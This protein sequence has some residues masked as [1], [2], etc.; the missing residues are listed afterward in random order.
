MLCHASKGVAIWFPQCRGLSTPI[1]VL[2]QHVSGSFFLIPKGIILQNLDVMFIVFV[3]FHFI[4][5]S[6]SCQC[7]FHIQF[8][9]PPF[10][11]QCCVHIAHH[12]HL[13]LQTEYFPFF[14]VSLFF[15]TKCQAFI[16]FLFKN[17]FPIGSSL[18]VFSVNEFLPCL[19][20]CVLFSCTLQRVKLP[21][22]LFSVVSGPIPPAKT[23]SLCQF[24]NYLYMNAKIIHINIWVVSTSNQ[25]LYTNCSR[26]RLKPF[27]ELIV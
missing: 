12:T 11:C 3:I 13:C 23:N 1:S 14:P 6:F 4:N 27:K 15:Q 26:V 7:C 25:Q 17:N 16:Y 19:T 20:S 5:P 18:L 2:A 22:Q 10:F 9:F 8:S 21:F 24:S